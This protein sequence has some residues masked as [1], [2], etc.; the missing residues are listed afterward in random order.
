MELASF[1]YIDFKYLSK[2]ALLIDLGEAFPKL[3]PPFNGI[4]T[5]VSYYSLKLLLES[6]VSKALNI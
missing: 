2:Q 3:S 4:K 6:K 1:S 5:P